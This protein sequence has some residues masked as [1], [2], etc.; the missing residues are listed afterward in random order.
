ME[1]ETGT[2][3]GNKSLSGNR[4]WPAVIFRGHRP[5][6]MLSALVIGLRSS[7]LVT[8]LKGMDIDAEVCDFCDR[9]DLNW[10]TETKVTVIVN[11]LFI[12]LNLV[13]LC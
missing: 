3:G 2:T 6:A 9:R 4:F 10:I 12:I 7:R 1:L 11:C 13:L 5:S 8:T